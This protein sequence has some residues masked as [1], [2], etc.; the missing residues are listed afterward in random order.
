MK[1]TTGL[2]LQATC[3]EQGKSGCH[4]PELSKEYSFSGTVTDWCLCTTCGHR[5]SRE[6]STESGP[7]T[8]AHLL[9]IEMTHSGPVKEGGE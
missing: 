5:V 3:Q 2:M 1:D 4:H 9:T 7:A 8:D 6:I